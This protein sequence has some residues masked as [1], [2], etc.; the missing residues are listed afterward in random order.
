M[1]TDTTA[2]HSVIFGGFGRDAIRDRVQDARAR[3]VI[4]ANE[5]LRGRKRVP[6]K[7][8]VDEGL[9]DCPFVS[10]GVRVAAHRDAGGD[11]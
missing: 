8:T 1:I 2:P 9:A 6:L 5:G 3:F 7:A 10:G 4:T 11:D